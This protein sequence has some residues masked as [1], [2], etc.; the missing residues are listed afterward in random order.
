MGVGGS[1]LQRLFSV[2]TDGDLESL[3]NR[4]QTLE[5]KTTRIVHEISQQV[6]MGKETWSELVERSRRACYNYASTGESSWRA[7]KGGEQMENKHL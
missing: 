7:G 3:R 1:T 5:Q 2:A 6:T 4:L